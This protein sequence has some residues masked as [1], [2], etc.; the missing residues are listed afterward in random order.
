MKLS[1]TIAG[2]AALSQ[3][4]N[5]H[6]R[7]ETNKRCPGQKF[8]SGTVL[9]AIPPAPQGQELRRLLSAQTPA[10]LYLLVAIMYIGRGDFDPADLLDHYVEVSDRLVKPVL[11]IETLLSKGV[12]GDLL[13]R[14]VIELAAVGVDVDGL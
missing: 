9:A 1:E 5:E 6:F 8:I 11:A 13:Q 2:I 7:V 4:R 10:M 3:A 14:G 12:V